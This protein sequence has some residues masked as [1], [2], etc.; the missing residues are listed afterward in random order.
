MAV[1][2]LCASECLSCICILSITH[3]CASE[4]LSCVCMLPLSGSPTY[5]HSLDLAPLSIIA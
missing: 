3:L 2:Y 5:T 1:I 4:C